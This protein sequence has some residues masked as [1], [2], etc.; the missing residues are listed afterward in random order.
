MHMPDRLSGVCIA[1]NNTAVAPVR[2][3]LRFGNIPR[4]QMQAANEFGVVVIQIIE[5][6]D[7]LF[8]N[9]QKMNRR[10]WIDVLESQNIII[11]IQCIGFNFSRH[12]FAKQAFVSH[13]CPLDMIHY[14]YITH[15]TP[16]TGSHLVTL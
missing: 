5:R 14:K 15:P 3:A 4:D 11:F 2:D 1:V 7:V 10:L 6:G 12:H 9:N 16:V 13:Y 8:G